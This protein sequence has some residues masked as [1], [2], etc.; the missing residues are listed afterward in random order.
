MHG[1]PLKN[2]CVTLRCPLSADGGSR[3]ATK[4]AG[5]TVEVRIRFSVFG[6]RRPAGSFKL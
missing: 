3:L 4:A 5:A 2:G 6:L 1:D